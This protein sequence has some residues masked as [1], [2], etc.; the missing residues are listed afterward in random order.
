MARDNPDT[1]GR[2]WTDEEWLEL[3]LKGAEREARREEQMREEVQ[4]LLND[5]LPPQEQDE[6]ADRQLVDEHFQPGL[7]LSRALKPAEHQIVTF[8]KKFADI[9]QK[10]YERASLSHPPQ[11]VRPCARRSCS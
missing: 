6:T 2:R 3:E 10:R 7:R 9:L 5:V 1:T 8:G 11:S 4:G